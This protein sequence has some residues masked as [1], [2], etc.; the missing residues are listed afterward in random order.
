MYGVSVKRK[1]INDI[2][3]SIPMRHILNTLVFLTFQLHTSCPFSC[4][5][6]GYS[7]Y[8]IDGPSNVSHQFLN[9]ESSNL[10]KSSEDSFFLYYRTWNEFDCGLFVI[11]WGVVRLLKS[12]VCPSMTL[13]V[14][15]VVFRSLHVLF[16]NI[17]IAIV[18]V[19]DFMLAIS[20]VLLKVMPKFH[21]LEKKQQSSIGIRTSKHE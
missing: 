21:P 13:S 11:F 17:C 10:A 8:R 3:M 7:F 16:Y 15:V 9:F 12:R 18:V 5:S 20:L 1:S 4:Q 19:N 14:H 2:N 6:L